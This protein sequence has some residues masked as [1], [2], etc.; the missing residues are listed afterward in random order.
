MQ[1]LST[2]N[3]HLDGRF[4]DTL[5][6]NDVIHSAL[7]FDPSTWPPT[8]KELASYGEE[9]IST[10]FHHYRVPLEKAG[11]SL[12]NCL[13]QWGELKVIVRRKLSFGRIKFLDLWQ[14]IIHEHSERFAD[15]LALVQI[16]LL[17]PVSTAECERGFSLMKRVKSDWR[18]RLR[19]DTLTGLMAITLSEE[20]VDMFSPDDAIG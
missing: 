20:E 1:V 8:A 18:N 4:K 16:I 17:L 13:V 19:A 2:I 6:S 15:I 10:I 12:A 9:K 5:L 7:V 3:Y 14:N 11:H